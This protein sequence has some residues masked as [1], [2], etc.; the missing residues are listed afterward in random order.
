MDHRRRRNL[1]RRS[2]PSGPVLTRGDWTRAAVFSLDRSTYRVVPVTSDRSRLMA[3]LIFSTSPGPYEWAMRRMLPAG[4]LVM[5]R[6]QLLTL[7][8]L[9]E[10]D[11][12]RSG[13]ARSL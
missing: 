6:K 13:S 4:D 2:Q 1:A 8:T 12:G 3:M 10:R 5:M 11:A 7:K 9:T